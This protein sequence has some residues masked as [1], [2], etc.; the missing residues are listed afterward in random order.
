MPGSVLVDAVKARF[1]IDGTGSLVWG[2]FDL[3]VTDCVQE[4]DFFYKGGNQKAEN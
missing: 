4:V 1:I 2:A 3:H